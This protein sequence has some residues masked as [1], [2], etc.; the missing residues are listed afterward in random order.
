M[1]SGSNDAGADAT[2][3]LRARRRAQTEREVEDSALRA[4][5]VHGFADTTMEE[6]AAGA[7]VSTSTAF[8]YFPAKV[9]TALHSARRVFQILGEQLRVDIDR[10]ASLAEMEDAAS[11]SLAA[12]ST[13]DPAV[14]ARLRQVR[15]LMLTDDRLRAEVAKSEGYL[16]GLKSR[17]SGIGGGADGGSGALLDSDLQMRLRIEI[18][19]ATLRAAFDAWAESDDDDDQ[20]VVVY[21]RTRALR[22]EAGF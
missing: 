15:K 11:S 7:G 3:G 13:S 19:A 9:D 20:L 22:D 10:G 14:I 12:L 8:R 16:V 17:A 6:I 1:D 21:A 18:T 4:F 2:G 5:T